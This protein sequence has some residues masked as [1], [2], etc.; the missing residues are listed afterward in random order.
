MT[1]D[2]SSC[3]ATP[4]IAFCEF[5]PDKMRKK[6]AFMFWNHTRYLILTITTLC[7]TSLT[8]N[9]LILNFTVICMGNDD[10]GL[11]SLNSSADTSEINSTAINE[12][13]QNSP[14]TAA[15]G[16]LFSAIAVGALIGTYP[17]IYL[18]DKIGIRY[19]MI[20]FGS[21]SAI[22]TLLGPLFASIGLWPLIFI[23]FLEGV[24]VSASFPIRGSVTAQWSTLEDNG[25]FISILSC[26]LQ[27]GPLFTMPVSSAFCTSKYGWEASFYLHGII[28]ILFLMIF[29]IAYCDDPVDHPCVS[30]KE[31]AAIEAGKNGAKVNK[32]MTVP[33]RA[34]LKTP[35]VWAIFVC[36]VGCTFA[37][38]LLYQYGPIYMNKVTFNS[39]V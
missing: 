4:L 29:F 13:N 20:V 6:C 33:Y 2:A 35:S 37:F 15:K 27:F 11:P 12:R 31:V 7:L 9:S 38:Q 5:D 3:T 34:M 16:L 23:R 28:T 21:I 14:S 39:Y 8:S 19:T 36:A 24:G 25:I 18:S 22:S 10:G 30:A 32:N 26:N 17:V 1:C